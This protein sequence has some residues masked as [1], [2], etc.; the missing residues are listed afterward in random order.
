MNKYARRTHGSQPTMWPIIDRMKG[1]SDIKC[2]KVS[3]KVDRWDI[4]FASIT[5][6]RTLYNS[7]SLSDGTILGW[8]FCSVWKKIVFNCRWTSQTENI[9]VALNIW[10]SRVRHIFC[11]SNFSN[12]P[13]AWRWY[14]SVPK[15]PVLRWVHLSRRAFEEK[16]L[17]FARIF[18]F[19][20]VFLQSSAHSKWT[21]WE[22]K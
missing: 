20:P 3:M 9:V 16:R 17:S 15:S 4:A 8:F 2:T 12:L 19:L 1:F 6:L 14:I 21:V 22:V 5:H 7:P 11:F 13:Y 10:E 18:V